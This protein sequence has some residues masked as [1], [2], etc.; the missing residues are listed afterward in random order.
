MVFSGWSSAGMRTQPLPLP[1]SNW[2]SMPKVSKSG[3]LLVLGNSA[4]ELAAHIFADPGP[5]SKAGRTSSEPLQ[6]SGRTQLGFKEI[7]SWQWPAPGRMTSVQG[8]PRSLLTSGP[9][10]QFGLAEYSLMLAVRWFTSASPLSPL[11]SLPRYMSTCCSPS[12]SPTLSSSPS[13]EG[14]RRPQKASVSLERGMSGAASSG[15][16]V[17]TP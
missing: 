2:R 12:D 15:L 1:S 14:G 6:T 3:A 4:T 11:R 16:E 13:S 9:F 10:P 8:F 5:A 17:D 7:Q